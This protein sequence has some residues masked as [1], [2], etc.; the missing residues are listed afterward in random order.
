MRTLLWDLPSV[1]AVYI[2]FDVIYSKL[3]RYMTSKHLCVK[4]I[5]C[6]NR[7]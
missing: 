6:Q 2:R 5:D 1:H 3:C 7:L 4:N